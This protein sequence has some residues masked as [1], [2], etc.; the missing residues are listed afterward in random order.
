MEDTIRRHARA[1]DHISDAVITMDLE[2]RIVDWNP[3][4][5]T[6]VRLHPGGDA[7]QDAGRPPAGRREED[8]RRAARGDAARRPLERR[9]ARSSARTA[10][11]GIVDTVVVPLFDDFGRTLAALA[12]CRDVTDRK[13]LE[14][15]RRRESNPVAS[16]RPRQKFCRASTGA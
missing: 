10:S 14:E 3:G 15:Y 6:D 1:F 8:R 16:R 9:D 13:R 12:V 4:A 11:S 7:R 5:E 2:A